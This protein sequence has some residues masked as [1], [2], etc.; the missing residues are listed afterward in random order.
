MS[1]GLPEGTPSDV[2]LTQVFCR[3]GLLDEAL[4]LQ[5]DVQHL[6]LLEVTA[7]QLARDP[8]DNLKGSSVQRLRLVAILFF[9]VIKTKIAATLAA[10]RVLKSTFKC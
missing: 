2:T 5:R 3:R 9:R 7:S 8:V 4:N 6:V 10:A 1:S